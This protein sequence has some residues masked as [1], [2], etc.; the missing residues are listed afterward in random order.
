MVDRVGRP[1]LFALVESAATQCRTFQ[2]RWKAEAKP[3]KE[4]PE[5]GASSGQ[6]IQAASRTNWRS[7]LD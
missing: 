4:T 3:G 6:C 2:L 1:V 5:P 7:H